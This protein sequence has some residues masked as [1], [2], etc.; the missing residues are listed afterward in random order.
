MNNFGATI[1]G[2]HTSEF[3]LKMTKMYISMPKPNTSYLSIPARSGALDMS[4]V[5]AGY[6]TY[7]DRTGVKLEFETEGGYEDW[8]VV[9]FNI[10][11]HIHGK[12]VKLIFDNDKAYYY[13]ARLE[14]DSK[15]S[16]EVL[17]SVVLQGRTEPFKYDVL[18]SDQEWEWDVFDFETGVIRELSDIEINSG[19]RI[20]TIFGG[21]Y[22]TA[23]EF[24]VTESN[25]LR[26]VYDGKNYE[27]PVGIARF[28]QIKV[29]EEDVTLPF[30]GTGRLAIRYRGA[31]L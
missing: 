24:V 17:H 5:T 2:I 27:L 23:P 22:P 8:E 11:R 30:D 4:D 7:A 21:C 18:A 15:K 16:D 31:Y 12:K 10:A 20:V 29:G 25:G 19:N 26:V 3:G 9:K 14:V 6:T 28:P 1:D 13:V